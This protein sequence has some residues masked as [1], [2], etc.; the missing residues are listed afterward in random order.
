MGDYSPAGGGMGRKEA[1]DANNDRAP[2][3]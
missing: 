1:S 2:A 3:Q